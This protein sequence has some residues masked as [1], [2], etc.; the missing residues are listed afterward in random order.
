MP[1]IRSRPP[2]RLS[3]NLKAWNAS[4]VIKNDNTYAARAVSTNSILG[5]KVSQGVYTLFK[6]N[7][8][9]LAAVVV[10]EDEGTSVVGLDGGHV[11]ADVVNEL[12]SYVSEVHS[13]SLAHMAIGVVA[14]LPPLHRHLRPDGHH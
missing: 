3:T 9:V 2:A 10:G 1:W 4:A 8:Y 5:S 11:Q 13:G 14:D 7:G 12:A 6:D